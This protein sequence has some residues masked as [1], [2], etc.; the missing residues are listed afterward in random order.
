MEDDYGYV[1]TGAP[2]ECS[3]CFPRG[4]IVKLINGECP[5]C[6]GR[7]A[8]LEATAEAELWFG[9]DDAP[10]RFEGEMG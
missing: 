8:F 5:E 10:F 2:D 1:Y 4:R 6:V 9:P 7:A 3:Y